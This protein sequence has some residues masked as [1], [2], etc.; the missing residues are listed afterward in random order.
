MNG[1]EVSGHTVAELVGST[2]SVAVSVRLSW[3]PSDPYAVELVF[4]TGRKGRAEVRW[5][6]ARDLL[7][8]GLCQSAGYGDVWV[9]PHEDAHTTVVELS[10]NDGV[11]LFEFDTGDLSDFLLDTYDQV[12]PGTEFM[13]IDLDTE[14]ERLME[15]PR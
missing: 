9:G 4:L 11:A 12:P 6:L 8:E 2:G 5:L 15:E 1:P 10:N 7:D 13:V 3:R 14:I